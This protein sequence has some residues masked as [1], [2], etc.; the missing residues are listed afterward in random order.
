MKQN[1]FLAASLAALCAPVAAVANNTFSGTLTAGYSFGNASIDGGGPSVNVNT[2]SLQGDLNLRFS[3]RFDADLGFTMLMVNPDLGPVDANLMAIDA[4]VTYRFDGGWRAGL[5][6]ENGDLDIN[7]AGRL[8]LISPEHQAYGVSFGYDAA[9]WQVT[10]FIGGTRIDPLDELTD[11]DILSYGLNATYT[12]ND[13]FTV[14]GHITRS[15]ID[16]GSASTNAMSFG[17]GAFYDIN[18]QFTVYGGL[19]RVGFDDFGFDVD[20]TAYSLGLAYTLSGESALPATF[21]L[22][23]V[24]NDLSLSSSGPN[25]SGKLDEIRFGVSIPLGNTTARRPLNSHALQTM[26][27]HHDVLSAVLP[28]Y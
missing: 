9:D 8:S 16:I 5:Y 18:E 7:N 22:E 1:L 21:S 3:D 13:Q 10:G 27:G 4:A 12:V 24:R 17:V 20:L 6:F 26:Q 14:G 19:S 2:A 25:G 23:L 15:N 11:Y 28:L